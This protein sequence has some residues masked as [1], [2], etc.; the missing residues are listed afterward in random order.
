[1]RACPDPTLPAMHLPIV[2]SL[3]LIATSLS[4]AASA[5]SDKLRLGIFGSGKGSGPLLTRAE[6]RECLTLQERVRS[7]SEVAVRDRD[8][9]EQEKSSL[10]RDRDDIKAALEKL[11]LANV[12]AVEQHKVRAKAHDLA[13]Q[14][15]ASR[16]DA[17]NGRIA[18]L[19]GDRAAFMQRCD[20]RR[21]DVVDEEAIRKGK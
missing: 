20:N 21:F 5:A 19:E 6:L 16:S 3:S 7:G 9:L 1:M 18:S 17:F 2:L 11:D 15:F 8:Q 14:D 13:I 10:T 12:E 4:G